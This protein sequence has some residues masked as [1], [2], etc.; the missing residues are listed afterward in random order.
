M[1]PAKLPRP[2]GLE[3]YAL[4][5][6]YHVVS[7]SR[8]ARE[9]GVSRDVVVRWLREDGLYPPPPSTRWSKNR[10]TPEQVGVT[11]EDLVTRF[12]SGSSLRALSRWAGV[13]H[14]VIRRWLTEAGMT[15]S[16]RPGR[17]RRPLSLTDE[18]LSKRQAN[19][20]SY[21]ELGLVV[22]CSRRTVYDRVQRY[23]LAARQE[24]A[25]AR[26]DTVSQCDAG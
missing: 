26:D 13:G 8:M 2:P 7:I 1:S 21:R 3:R 22:G 4:A 14:E 16:V 12:Q 17:P 19:G 23:R 20:A 15:I 18:E 10:L 5:H 6:W 11:R 25:R 24:A 9:C